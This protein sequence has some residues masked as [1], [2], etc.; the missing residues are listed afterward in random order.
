MLKQAILLLFLCGFAQ[1][2]PAQAIPPADW[3]I[4]TALMAVPEEFRD[5]ARVYGYDP[6]GKFTTLRQG[7]N[8]YIALA[9]DPTND[10]FSTAAYHKDLD[11]FMARGRE[12]KAQGKDF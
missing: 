4:R 8:D 10:S 5:G 1:Q 3:Q 6:S 11:P 2:L 12:L 9:D 7:T